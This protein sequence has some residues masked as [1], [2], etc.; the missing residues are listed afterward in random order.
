MLAEQKFR[1]RPMFLRALRAALAVGLGLASLA[2]GAGPTGAASDSS[3]TRVAIAVPLLL[4][5]TTDGL[6]PAEDLAEYT[7]AFGTLTRQLEALAD[8]PVAIG[9]DPRIIA[10]IRVLGTSAPP[11]ALDWLDRLD[12]ATNQTFPLTWA[13]ADITLGTQAGSGRVLDSIGLDFAIDPSLFAA[14]STATPSPTPDPAVPA[15]PTGAELSAWPYSLT[16][17]A[18]PRE[19]TV[20]ASDLKTIA[21]S[22]YSSTIVSSQNVSAAAEGSAAEISGDRVVISDAALSAA[23][24]T[25]A[26]AQTEEQWSSAYAALSS[27]LASSTGGIVLMTLDREPLAPVNRLA[28][29]LGALAADPGLV[30]APFSQA[31]GDSPTTA[32]VVDSP[33]PA[34]RVGA[35]EALLAA[36]TAEHP[37]ASV[38]ENP[39]AITSSRR[40][41]LLAV[42][43]GV[44]AANPSG[45]SAAVGDYLQQ[46]TDLRNSVRV[47]GGSSFNFL[48][49]RAAL[50]ISVSNALDQAVTVYVTVRPDT[51]L[52]AVEND[53]V[54]LVIE[55]NSQG[56]AQVPVQAVSNGVVTVT[57]SLSNAAGVTI[58][59][60]TR[61]EINVQAGWETPVVVVIAAVVVAIFGFG[62][63]RNILRRRKAR[64][65]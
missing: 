56:K 46:S 52:L 7:S 8:R 10:S 51:A 47:V 41:D 16:G 19:G 29:T 48:A 32:T 17:I 33:Q 5:A 62:I 35:T 30:L 22:G 37:F 57:V 11:S 63:V 59:D 36:E 65:D 45:W 26:E 40:L 18:W 9:I 38:A 2:F 3:P 64:D 43:S 14:A 28:A 15:L 61:A 31:V 58:G 55:P 12:R 1:G 42:L 25:T 21:S 20:V 6:I 34:D 13:D 54:E 44:W 23:L 60:A 53:R 4:P 39:A 50:P 24:R 49:A 27:S